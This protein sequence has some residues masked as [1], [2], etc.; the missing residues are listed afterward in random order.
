MT[1]HEIDTR[2]PFIVYDPRATANGQRC[3]QLVESVDIYPTICDLAGIPVNK[4]DGRSFKQLLNQPK[5]DFKDAVFSQFMQRYKGK[6][7]MGY[8]VRTD[9]YRYIEWREPNG[10]IAFREL[11]DQLKDPQENIN[12]IQSADIETASSLEKRLHSN[13]P[14]RPLDRTPRS[15]FTDRENQMQA[16]CIQCA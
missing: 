8:A 2:I 3:N 5:S 12:I 11:Y 13:N 4:V 1:N 14:V 7:H 15:S 6:Q 16:R 9:R 10:K